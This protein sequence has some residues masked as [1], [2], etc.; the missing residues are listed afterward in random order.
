MFSLII[1]LLIAAVGFMMAVLYKRTESTAA[2]FNPDPNRLLKS[3]TILFVVS[4][5]LTFLASFFTMR[6]L[7]HSQIPEEGNMQYNSMK[8]LMYFVLNF[9]FLVLMI[10]V[11]L[12]SQA[13][14]GGSMGSVSLSVFLLCAFCNKGCLLS[15]QLLH[16]LAESYAIAYRRN[17]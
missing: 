16:S 11:N 14:K 8:E 13:R 5:L 7:T 17:T 10:N 1:Y 4:L 15:Y 3:F 2:F 12:Y 6:A 9:F